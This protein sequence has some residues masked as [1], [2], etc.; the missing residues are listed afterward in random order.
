MSWNV[1][2][3]NTH[4]KQSE[5]K[6]LISYHKVGLI[7]L[8]ETRVKAHKLGA[9]YL[10]M[11]SGWCFISNNAWHNGGCIVVAWNPIMFSVSIIKCSSQL[12]HL[13]VRPLDKGNGFYVSFVYGFNEEEGRVGLWKEISDCVTQEPWLVLGDFNDILHKDGRIGVKVKYSKSVAFQHCIEKCNLEDVKFTGSFFTWTN[14]QQGDDRIYSKID[15]VMAN[16]RWLDWYTAAEVQQDW[17]EVVFG[18][19]M[20][21]VV[22]KL[23]RLKILLK[24][25]NKK[26]FNELH[27]THIKALQ[28]LKECQDHLKE[29]L[30][31]ELLIVQESQAGK[32]YSE[33]H[34]LYCSFLHQKAKVK[35]L[36]EG[37]EN[38]TFFHASL[39]DRIAQNRIYSVKA[40]TGVWVDK[41]EDVS[42]VFLSYYQT[43]LGC[44]LENRFSVNRNVVR[45]GRVM[46][47][48]QARP[49]LEH[50]SMEDVKQYVFSIP[51]IKAPGPNGF[52]AHNI[53]ICQ[54]L[55]RHY[56]QKKCKPSCM[57]KLDLRKAYDTIEGGFIEEMLDALQF[58]GEFV[59]LIMN[60]AWTPR[61]SLMFNGELHGFFESKRGLRQGDPLSPLLFVL[62]MEYLSR[63]MGKVGERAGFRFHD[64]CEELRL[65][66]LSFA[67]DIL[68]FCHGDFKSVY[69]ILQGLKLFSKTSGLFPSEEKSAIYCGGMEETKVQRILDASGF[70]R[71]SLP[72]R[73]LGVPICAKKNSAMECSV[74]LEKMT[75]RIRQWSTRNLS[76][77]GRITLINSVLISIHSY[78][79]QLF[80]I[81]KRILKEINAICRAFLWHGTTISSNSGGVAWEKIYRPKRAGGL[82]FRNILAWNK[83]ALGKYVWAISSTKD[84]LWVKWINSVYIK[85]QV[86]WDYSA[87]VQSSWYWKKVVAVK[88]TLKT[89]VDE[90][91]FS[92]GPY[93]IKQ[94]YELI[95]PEGD[96]FQ[97]SK[98]VWSRFNIPKHRFIFWLAVQ[99]HLKTRDRL[100]KFGILQDCA[101]LLCG[102]EKE[103]AAHLFFECTVSK[104]CLQEVKSWLHW[105]VKSVSLQHLVRWNNCSKISKFKKLCFAACLAAL[106]YHLWQSRNNALWSLKVARLDII[107]KR[108]TES[109]KN[110]I[111]FVWP[112]HIGQED[113]EWFERL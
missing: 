54:D 113:I 9:L 86:W 97:W 12:I 2:G 37:D 71:S 40:E 92:V 74:L 51:G 79:S 85:D 23:K 65:N 22:R 14:K 88:D 16:Q 91:Q 105:Q 94:G 87:P 108:I 90:Y 112:K 107:V 36:Q 46:T 31:N 102:V 6:K 73:H 34:K 27:S 35:W 89:L 83:A 81:P 100:F 10:H 67:D 5:V 72:F 7:G 55:V 111:L 39:R 43:L 20:F 58:P 8:L 60:C 52:I 49:L 44:K 3:L 11:F 106:V 82:G 29:D 70:Q 45:H 103:S 41:P 62:G 64:H 1:R 96:S 57:I 56:G 76:F 110:R 75:G 69:L 78:W 33:V 48:I 32:K 18:T 80:L 53:M 68:L 21:R 109:V 99:D 59:Q 19:P 50:Y 84:D 42:S 77:A 66:H 63:I 104:R 30:L 61:F 4:H 13:L 25:L 17:K 93:R 28:D 98:E 26:G 15:R 38:T 101:C 24:E 95:W 47:D